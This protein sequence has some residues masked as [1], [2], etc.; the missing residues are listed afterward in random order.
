MRMFVNKLNRICRLQRSRKLCLF[1]SILCF[2]VLIYCLGSLIETSTRMLKFQNQVRGRKLREKS[3]VIVGHYIGPGNHGNLSKNDLNANNF[4]PIPGEGENG[5]P[6][7]I[8]VKD[9]LRMQQVFQ[10]NRFNL[11]ASDRISLNRSLPDVRRVKCVEKSYSPEL[12]ST[13]VIIVFHNEAWSVLLRTV[14]SVITRS[15]R[16][17]LK[18]IILVDDASE[19]NFLHEPLES[20]ISSLPVSTKI[21][22]LHEREGLVAAR[23]LGAERARGDALVFLDAHCE[24]SPGWLEPLLAEVHK[25]RRKVAC[26]VIDII[27]DDNFSYVKSFELHWGA[28]NWQLHFRWFALASSE[29]LKRRNDITT[30]FR[31]PAMAGGL[32]AIDREYFYE[33]GAYDRAMKIWGGENMEL[34][35]RVWQCGGEIEIVPCSHVGHLFR[36]SSPYTF[37][38]GVNEILNKNLARV[39]LV[40][41]DEWADFFFKFNPTALRIGKSE[42]VTDR[43]DLRKSLQC[44]DFNWYLTNVWPQHF[45]PTEERFF[46][47]IIQISPGSRLN[48]AYKSFLKKN[49]VNSDGDYWLN[50]IKVTK[51]HAEELRKLIERDFKNVRCLMRSASNGI[52]NQFGQATLE[53]CESSP[54]NSLTQMFVITKEGKIMTDENLC[55]DA[56]EKAAESTNNSTMVRLIT[57]ADTVRQ[58]WLY[59]ADK[60]RIL[61]KISSFC[62]NRAQKDEQGR[63]TEVVIEKCSQEVKESWIFI[64]Y[65]WR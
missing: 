20:Y 46:G 39:A 8:P 17:F 25:D 29:L 23:L 31:T 64:P 42:N 60:L 47:R 52:F 65:P 4:S 57:C 7:A 22:R 61:H 10:V 6:V 14:W 11:L 28:F 21:F 32:F 48:V 63:R 5:K 1:L 38:G 53:P 41:M 26:P 56:S 33:I 13:S 19:R 50:L 18:E 15:P 3:R 43:L 45:Y 35:F 30:P 49:N 58:S 16:K 2:I 54:Q 62:F 27:S 59:D 12:P 51:N 24:C 55:L 34:S 9:M 36:K 40:W 37:P 44:K